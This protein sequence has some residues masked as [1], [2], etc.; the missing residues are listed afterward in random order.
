MLYNVIYAQNDHPAITIWGTY[1]NDPQYNNIVRRNFF[2]GATDAGIRVTGE[3]AREND[4]VVNSVHRGI[5]IRARDY[6]ARTQYTYV[7]NST[8]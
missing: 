1:K 8:V 4:I 7:I 3:T 5:A 2:Y 6:D